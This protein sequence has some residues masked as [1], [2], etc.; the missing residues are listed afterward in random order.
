M[1]AVDPVSADE[2]VRSELLDVEES[3][4]HAMLSNDAA[5]IAEF[6]TDDWVIV[7]GSGV[8]SRAQFLALVES[9]ILSHSVM[10][11][12]GEC[13]VRAYGDVAVLSI[14]VKSAATYRGQET[15]ADEWT[16]DVFVRRNGGW[17]CA[18]THIAP[19]TRA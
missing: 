3:W 4:G 6:V 13:R 19:V 14:R 8:T 9:G 11:L 1:S 17:R 7:S 2:S 16:T 12:V 5:A 18:L 15:D 10:T